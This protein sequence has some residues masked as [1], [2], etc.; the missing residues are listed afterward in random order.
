MMSA[1]ELETA[2]RLGLPI[3]C[4]IFNDGG[5]GLIAWKQMKKFGREFGCRFKNPDFVKF[6]ES[7]GAKGYRVGAEDELSP[8]IKDA[9]SQKVPSVIDCP[10]DYSEN[11]KL[12]ETLKSIVCPT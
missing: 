1:A 9:L 5:Y 12:T 3:V 6:A 7:F 8:I 11:L 10:V 4:L 2:V